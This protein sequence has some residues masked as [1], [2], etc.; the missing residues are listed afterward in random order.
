MTRARADNPDGRGE[1]P[2][3]TNGSRQ[4]HGSIRG[5]S[6]HSRMT[7]IARWKIS[8]WWAAGD[9]DR[10]FARTFVKRGDRLLVLS[11]QYTMI[12]RRVDAWTDE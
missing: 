1:G 11:Q 10:R 4:T 5:P 7:C 9:G 2:R 6:H 12:A 8:A 3:P